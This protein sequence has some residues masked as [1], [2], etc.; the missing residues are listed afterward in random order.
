M[1]TQKCAAQERVLKMIQ[2]VK[3]C[4]VVCDVDNTLLNAQSGLPE[5]NKLTIELFMSMGGRF[6]VATGRTTESVKRQLGPLKIN[7]PAITYGGSVIYD[8]EKKIWLQNKVL[9]QIAAMQALCDIK[10]AVP[11]IGIEVMTSDGRLYVVQSNEYTH[12]HTVYERLIY[13]M[14]PLGEFSNQWNKVMFAGAPELLLK[15]QDFVKN[16]RY[17]G[18][19]FVFTDEMYFEMMPQCVSKGSA[20]KELCALTG[21]PLENTIAIGDYD[22]DLEMLEAAGYAVAMENAPMKLQAVADEIT[23][24]CEDGGVAQVLYGLIRKYGEDPQDRRVRG[25]FK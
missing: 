22:N 11:G 18:L 24:R 7:A 9:P 17:P 5:V 1:R 10:E 6:T 13:T 12:H 20:L 3:D 2:S 19:Y 25:Y 15:A 23:T 4:L 8:F 14:S 16:R 21:I